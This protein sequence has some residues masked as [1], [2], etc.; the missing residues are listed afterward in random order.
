M[1]LGYYLVVAG[2]VM[3]FWLIALPAVLY[4]VLQG[5]RK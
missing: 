5:L 1:E 4:T 3:A 2:F